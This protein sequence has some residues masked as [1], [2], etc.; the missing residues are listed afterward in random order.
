[1]TLQVNHLE[2]H[3][4]WSPKLQRVMK[5]PTSKMKIEALYAPSRADPP[6][7]SPLG[8]S[9]VILTPLSR[10]EMGKMSDGYAPSPPP[11]K[12]RKAS[13]RGEASG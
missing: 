10:M 4:F 5:S 6:A 12:K 13:E 2:P 7:R 8:A 1:V 3:Y 11:P 9:L